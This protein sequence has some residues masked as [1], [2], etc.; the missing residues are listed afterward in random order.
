MSKTVAIASDHAGFALKE[1]LRS[2]I[3][4]L[5]FVVVDLGTNST[6]S[7]DYPDFGYMVADSISLGKAELGIVV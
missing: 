4:E 6:E 5:G 7:V 1:T 3:A 2:Y